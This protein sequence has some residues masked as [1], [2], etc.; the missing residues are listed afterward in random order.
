[1]ATRVRT[2]WE[3][4]YFLEAGW[5]LSTFVSEYKR[6]IEK[7]YRKWI[8]VKMKLTLFH[9]RFCFSARNASFGN[10]TG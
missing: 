3:H 5:P 6:I 4:D 9:L 8:L 10:L 7:D 1:M 2:E